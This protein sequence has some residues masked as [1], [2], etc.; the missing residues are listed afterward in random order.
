W[1]AADGNGTP[2]TSYIVRWGG[3]SKVVEAPATSTSISG[4]TNGTAYRFTVEA[5]NGFA[6]EGGVSTRSKE[7]NSITPYTK[8][9]APTVSTSAA[10]CT[11]SSKCPVTFNAT[12][13]GSDGGAGGKTLQVRINGGKW[14]NVSGTSFTRTVQM[15]SGKTGTIE[16]RVK[17]AKGLYSSTAK[18]SQKAQKWVP[19]P[20]PKIVNAG[21][22]GSAVN[23]QNCTSGYCYFIDFTVTNLEP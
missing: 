10:K 13:T 1:S 20:T 7:S 8:P 3:Q 11:G 2:V 23:E 6:N 18:K 22:A 12:A 14:E 5:R 9:A 15:G 16:A 21:R 4:L 17:N 19:A